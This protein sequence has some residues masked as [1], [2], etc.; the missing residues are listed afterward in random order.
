MAIQFL[1]VAM[2]AVGLAMLLRSVFACVQTSAAH[3][4]RP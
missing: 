1:A 4:G 3:C 2:E